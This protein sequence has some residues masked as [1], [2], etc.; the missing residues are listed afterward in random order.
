MECDLAVPM[1]LIALTALALAWL[2]SPL[3]YVKM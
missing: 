3:V 1:V 2:S